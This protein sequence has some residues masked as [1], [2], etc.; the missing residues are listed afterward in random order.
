[1][2][3]TAETVNPIDVRAALL[4]I[5]LPKLADKQWRPTPRLAAI[6]R[7]LGGQ[8]SAVIASGDFR[9]AAGEA[10]LLYPNGQIPSQRVQL[11]GLGEESAI[12]LV[13]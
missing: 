8:I 4:V 10:L 5:P 12:L 3:V 6:D 1:M 2:Q 7:A 9:G 13:P 11:L